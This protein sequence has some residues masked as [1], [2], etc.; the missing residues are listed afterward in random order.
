MKSLI[1]VDMQ[2]DFMP[3]GALA[4]PGADELVEP[5]NRLMGRFPLVVASRDRHPPEHT[6][7]ASNHE[8]RDPGEVVEVEGMRQ[9][10]WP[11][12][13][14]ADTEGAEFVSGLDLDGIDHVVLKGT[15]PRYDSY[16]TFFDNGHEH[17]T[18]LDAFLKSKAVTAVWIVGVATEVCIRFTALD[19]IRCG[20]ETHLVRD[21]CRGV[22]MQEGDIAGALAQMEDAGVRMTES[23]AVPDVS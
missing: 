4:V 8:G 5:I 12:H 9:M 13:C 16:S 19:A 18:G 15:D 20:Y 21:L 22:E 6:S 14:V 1:I 2:N 17:S 10:L 23:G 3:G 7:F 11:D